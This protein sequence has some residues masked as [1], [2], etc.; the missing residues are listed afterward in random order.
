MD[1]FIS[2]ISIHVLGSGTD[3][4]VNNVHSEALLLEFKS[5]L[6]NFPAT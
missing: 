4:A 5:Q 6:Y 1:L 3:V 2:F